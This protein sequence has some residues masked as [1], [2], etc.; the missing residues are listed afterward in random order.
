MIVI[1]GTE[2][3]ATLDGLLAIE[4]GKGGDKGLVAIYAQAGCASHLS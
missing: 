1:R 3:V 4:K 2:E